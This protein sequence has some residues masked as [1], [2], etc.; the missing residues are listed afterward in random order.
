MISA[1]NEGVDLQVPPGRHQA[2]ST[3]APK[4]RH[5]GSDLESW[6][7][8]AKAI[9]SGDG[10]GHQRT[11]DEEAPDEA[12]ANRTVCALH[13]TGVA[14]GPGCGRTP[15]QGLSAVFQVGQEA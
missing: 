8:L 11:P 3:R 2:E 1:A 7:G 6:P 10:K 5:G 12:E 13:R 15:G 9:R 14:S 4:D